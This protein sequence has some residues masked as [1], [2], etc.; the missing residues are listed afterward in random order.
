MERSPR[1]CRQLHLREQRHPNRPS[2]RRLSLHPKQCTVPASTSHRPRLE[3]ALLGHR[4]PRRLRHVQRPAGRARLPHGS[5]RALQPLVL[6]RQSPRFPFPVARISD[7]HQRKNRTS[8]R[9]AG[10]ENA[11]TPLLVVA[12]RAATHARHRPHPGLHRLARLSRDRLASTTTSPRPPSA[13]LPHALL[14]TLR[15][16]PR[17]SPAPPF[18]RDPSTF[19]PALPSPTPLL[20]PPGPGSPAA[21]VHTTPSRSM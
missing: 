13:P 14:H 6:H 10:H 18:L 11:H 2:H 4:H 1:P 16:F 8:R 15:V 5:E 20:E 12:H 9:S 17:H 21:T 19:P 3:P 7:S